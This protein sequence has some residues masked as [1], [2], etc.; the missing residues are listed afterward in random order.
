MK[1]TVFNGSPR[2][3]GSNTKVL[4]DSF[5]EGFMRGGG[6]SYQI[7]YIAGE[8]RLSNLAEILARSENVLIAFPLYIDCMPAVTLS[9]FENL[10]PFCGS[11]KNVR[12][13]FLVQSGF[14]EPLNSR[15]VEKYHEKLTKRLGAHYIGTIVRG[16]VRSSSRGGSSRVLLARFESLGEY[17]GRTASLDSK[18]VKELAPRDR[19]SRPVLSMLRILDKLGFLDRM[20]E[21]SLK[22]KGAYSKRYDRPYL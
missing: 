2:R 22:E 6:N 4:L 19:L 18:I 3:E 1:L 8:N 7:F 17:F 12:L 20:W 14:P 16:G 9:F 21:K 13:C 11:L 15:P 5:I 10:E